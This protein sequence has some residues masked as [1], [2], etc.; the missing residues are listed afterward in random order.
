MS[1]IMILDLVQGAIKMSLMLAAPLLI[2]SLS[3]GL[4]VSIF[5]ATT[6]IQEQTLTFVPKLIGISI[7]LVICGPWMLN[8]IVNYTTELFGIVSMITKY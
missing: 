7:V 3:I 8:T 6:Q 2:T 4:L 1:I 5:Q